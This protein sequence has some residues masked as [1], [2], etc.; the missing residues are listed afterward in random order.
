LDVWGRLK[1]LV[2]NYTYYYARIFYVPYLKVY[3]EF[4][5][6]IEQVKKQQSKVFIEDINEK[7]AQY[8]VKDIVPD[9]YLRLGDTIFHYLIDE[10]Q[11]TSPVQWYNLLPLV[12]NSVSQE[13]S[14]FVVGDTKQAIY[15]FREADYHIMKAVETQNPFPS[16]SHSVSEL[17]KNY[18]SR[19]GIIDF[20]EE[21][22]KNK[23]VEQ[24]YEMPARESELLF[25][26]QVSEKK[27]EHK[28]VV[29]ITILDKDED[30]LPERSKVQ[31]LITDLR[32]RGYRYRD[33]A[34]LTPRNEDVVRV[35]TWLNEKE[36]PFI[37]LSSLDIRRRKITGEIMA[38]LSFLDS[39]LDDLS[40]AVFL[41]GSIFEKTLQQSR[42]K[43]ISK[44]N[45][46]DLH[47]FLFNHHKKEPLYKSFQKE[48]TPVW[49]EYLAPLFKSAGYLP[50]YELVTE[51]FRSF[52][53]FENLPEEEATLCRI[54]EVIK[55]FE[56]EDANSLKSFIRTA[57]E[58]PD[59]SRWNMD[60]PEGTD[61]VKVMTVHKAKGLG[62]PVVISL[63]YNETLHRGFP[64]I[65]EESGD[66]ISF[67]KIN[68]KIAAKNKDYQSLYNKEKVKE[69][70][71]SLNKLYV[72]FTRAEK[73]MYILG[74]KGKGDKYPFEI[75][76]TDKYPG[77]T[78]LK[79]GKIE[80]DK[81][82]SNQ[83]ESPASIGVYHLAQVDKIKTDTP[84]IYKPQAF[85]L[86]ETRRGD[87]IHAI[88]AR[89]DY[90]DK[91]GKLGEDNI[92][93]V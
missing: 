76:P 45:K 83:E 74:I 19:Q 90:L 93:S 3:N 25:W 28:G 4:K 52:K 92:N 70:V 10:F 18:R 36:I 17:N 33:I 58:E 21:V 24:G 62:F 71:N 63:L 20:N 85:N 91:D 79:P 5:Q 35:T 86:E 56:G 51:I 67:L 53:I 89:I 29:A 87:L 14:L 49:E 75:L 11:D 88:L 38:V 46:K 22:F 13:G 30:K 16:A 73:E 78:G 82:D 39:P 64:F 47:V 6:T 69:E 37:S 26:T 81:P 8:L 12:E 42:D 34:V 55:D 60:V 48:F 9:V 72:G 61:A 7:L 66:K 40:L 77:G 1:L 23:V 32:T 68:E 50:L 44:I 41:L 2:N 57:E 80:K 27:D 15:V 65:V 31:E 84:D 59:E 54:L 43:N